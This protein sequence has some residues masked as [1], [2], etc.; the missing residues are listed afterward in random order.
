MTFENN[1]GWDN[2][3]A[4]DELQAELDAAEPEPIPPE[5]V[6]IMAKEAMRRAFSDTNV[7]HSIA[8]RPRRPILWSRVF[9]SVAALVLAVATGAAGERAWEK[10]EIARRDAFMNLDEHVRVIKLQERNY[11]AKFSGPG[12]EAEVHRLALQLQ[13]PSLSL[14]ERAIAAVRLSNLAD[15]THNHKY[16]EILCQV[17]HTLSVK[18]SILR[19]LILDIDPNVSKASN[20]SPSTSTGQST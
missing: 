12:L 10:L 7:T 18:D 9:R 8:T 14:Q 15:E 19:E 2:R 11:F 3:R 17:W 4:R 5:T 1:L 20:C 13:N 6:R 16:R